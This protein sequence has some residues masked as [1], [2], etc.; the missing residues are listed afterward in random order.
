M[1]TAP[2]GIEE[3]VWEIR[4]IQNYDYFS[5]LLFRRHFKLMWM[6]LLIRKLVFRKL[7]TKIY[8]LKIF[9]CKNKLTSYFI[10]R[11]KEH[12]SDSEWLFGRVEVNDKM[13]KFEAVIED[14]VGWIAVD[15]ILKDIEG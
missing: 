4:S 15:E 8:L 7:D 3:T 12:F 9:W 6:I 10:S 5:L 1:T 2:D 11:G 14:H 13:I